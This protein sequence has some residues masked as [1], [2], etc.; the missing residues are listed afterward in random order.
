VVE[1]YKWMRREYNMQEVQD[2]MPR[3]AKCQI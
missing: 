3:V 1:N 2:P